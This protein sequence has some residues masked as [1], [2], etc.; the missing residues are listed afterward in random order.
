[1]PLPCISDVTHRGDPHIPDSE[2]GNRVARS[3]QKILA[4]PVAGLSRAR[5]PDHGKGCELCMRMREFAIALSMAVILL[6]L[7]AIIGNILAATLG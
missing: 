3:G 6:T 2:A 1:M 7:L 4:E 5:R